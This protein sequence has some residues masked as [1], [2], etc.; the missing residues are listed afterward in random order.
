MKSIIK[1]HQKSH[2]ELEIF[3]SAQDAQKIADRIIGKHNQEVE[4]KGFRKGKAPKMMV[5]EKV[6][7]GKIQQEI[8]NNIV[9]ESYLRS[10]KEHKFHPISQPSI[11]VNKYSIKPDGMVEKD[12]EFEL[13]VDTMPKIKLGDYTKIK[14]KDKKILQKDINVS[15]DELEKVI[16]H[17]RKQKSEFKPVDREVKNGD[18]VEISFI[19]KIDKIADE[20]L[21]SDH[22][23]LVVGSGAMIPGFEDGLIGMK[24]D[25]EKDIEIV[26]PESYHSKQFANKRVKFN[27]KLHEVKEVILPELNDL[28][29]KQFGH[30]DMEKLKSA[31]ENQLKYEKKDAKEKQIESAIL[32]EA[33]KLLE[34]EI[35]AGLLNSETDRLVN[36]LR[37][38]VEKQG[39]EFNR[40]LD[41]IKKSE[42]EFRQELVPQAK[43]NIEVGFI[44]GEVIMREKIDPHKEG[45][46]RLAMEKLVAYATKN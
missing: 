32:E 5:I 40:Y 13:K 30:D 24:K 34:V 43:T 7:F 46:T 16:E 38:S 2:I 10:I 18:W 45:A 11:A 42:E 20:R 8:L 4:V 6:G 36:K 37:E 19:G 31:I 39:I 33:R 35:P 29:A 26:F 25:A 9:E 41:M 3:C 17:L 23:P 15:K 28:F 21:K 14:I 27:I 12:I 44:L 22:H 1:K